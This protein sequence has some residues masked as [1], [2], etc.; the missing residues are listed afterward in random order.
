MVVN[1]G[2]KKMET[3]QKMADGSYQYECSCGMLWDTR[4]EAKECECQSKKPYI[5]KR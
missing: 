5:I 3:K 2:V 1:Q 4:K